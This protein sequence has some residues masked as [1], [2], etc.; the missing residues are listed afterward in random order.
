MKRKE[1]GESGSFIVSIRSADHENS[2][3]TANK[4]SNQINLNLFKLDVDRMNDRRLYLSDDL[5]DE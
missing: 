2:T 5:G 1:M 3:L 4:M